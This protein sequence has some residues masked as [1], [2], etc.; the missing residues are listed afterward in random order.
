MKKLVI[1]LTALCIIFAG[2]ISYLI[3]KDQPGD[4]APEASG[5][6]NDVEESAAPIQVQ[7]FDYD[8]LYSS[9]EP[10][11]IVGQVNGTDVRWD[12]FCYWVSTGAAQVENYISSMAGYG[13]EA[14]WDDPWSQDSDQT[15]YEYVVATAVENIRQFISIEDF[16]AANDVQLSDEILAEIENGIK[17]TIASVCGEDATEEDFDEHL[18]KLHLTREIYER[19]IRMNYLYQQGFIKLYGENGELLD[20]DAALAYLNANDYL[21]AT[22]ILLMTI[23]PETNEP[24][25]E[26]TI[27]NIKAQAEELAAELQA[28][29]NQKQLMAR[30]AELKEEYCQDTGKAAFPDGY[31]FTP[32]TMVAEFEDTCKALGNYQ[33]SDPVLTSYGYHIIMRLPLSPDSV[34]EYSSNGTALTGRSSAANMEYAGKMDAQLETAVFTFAPEFENLNIR[35]FVK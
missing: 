28:I 10:D 13:V 16:A 25:D 1:V 6:V 23:D 12:M 24:L 17:E 18:A 19:M 22:H 9:H 32:G 27:E 14:S 8:A 34:V 4:K 2:V 3:L 7:K 35:E 20:D 26:K 15:F 11:E 33:V 29:T 21:S 30:F 31:T 5:P